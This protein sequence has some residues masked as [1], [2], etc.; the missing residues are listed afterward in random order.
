MIHF[1]LLGKLG[2]I[3]LFNR[4]SWNYPKQISLITRAI[5]TDICIEYGCFARVISVEDIAKIIRSDDIVVDL[6]NKSEQDDLYKNNLKI[7]SPVYYATLDRIEFLKL[8]QSNQIE[9]RNHKTDSLV[10]YW[11]IQIERFLSISVDF[12]PNNLWELSLEKVS[13]DDEIDILVSLQSSTLNKMFDEQ[14]TRYLADMLFRFGEQNNKKVIFLTGPGD[15]DV[16]STISDYLHGTFVQYIYIDTLEE[17]FKIIKDSKIIIS[18]DN[19]IKHISAMFGK[20]LIV[21]YGPTSNMICG[22][23]K[24]E[25]SI[26][27]KAKCSPCGNINECPLYGSFTKKCL[28]ITDAVEVY[29]TL[30]NMLKENNDES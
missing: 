29:Q 7:I 18:V 11:K 6:H 3:I 5:F 1:V 20:K 27:S 25:K 30:E 8:V 4:L 10:H 15:S 9:K 16:I 17:L 22:S 24:M 23:G 14:S 13:S 26:L 19:G 12:D 21:A 28:S 2:D